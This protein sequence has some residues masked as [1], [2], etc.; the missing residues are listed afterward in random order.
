MQ[1]ASLRQSQKGTF[2]LVLAIVLSCV[3]RTTPE[4]RVQQSLA[5]A[6]TSALSF[7]SSPADHFFF[8]IVG[9]LHIGQGDTTRMSRVLNGATAD[10]AEFILFLGDIVDAGVRDDVI[11]FNNAIAAAGWTGRTFSVAGNHDVFNDGWDNYY[12]LTGSS[13]YTFTAGNSRFIALDSAD[14]TLGEAQIDWL[15]GQLAANT[16]D[17]VF[18]FSHYLPVIPGQST[19]LK[20]AS[21]TESLGLMSLATTAGVRGWLG[22]HYHSFIQSKIAGVDYVVAGG[23]G[24]RRMAP[25]ARYFYVLVEV[26]GQTVTYTPRPID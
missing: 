10:G 14:A 17:N 2:L 7:N 25:Y 20:L 15:R 1:A 11:A 21:E 5:A 24:G 8:V 6:S 13:T 3:S 12:E 26:N 18:L 4:E 9:D 23:G 19:Y 16:S 22:A